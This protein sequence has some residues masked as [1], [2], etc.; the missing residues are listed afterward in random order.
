[1]AG[2]PA[3]FTYTEEPKASDKFV[4]ANLTIDSTLLTD[5][6]VTILPNIV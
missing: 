1:M 6:C 3:E 2:M 4:D 5:V